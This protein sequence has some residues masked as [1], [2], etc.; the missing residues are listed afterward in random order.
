MSAKEQII[1]D[2]KPVMKVSA[3]VNDLFTLLL[4]M[5]MS[6]SSE[7]FQVFHTKHSTEHFLLV[8]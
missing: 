2:T 8:L 4:H 1:S 3:S 5:A 7:S 6:W